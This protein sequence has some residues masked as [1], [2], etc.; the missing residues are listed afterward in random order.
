MVETVAAVAAAP[1][2][3]KKA[4]QTTLTAGG[5][6]PSLTKA[7]RASRL[8]AVVSSLKAGLKGKKF[9]GGGRMNEVSADTSLPYVEFQA[10]FESVGTLVPPEKPTSKVVT[11]TYNAEELGA[12]F[13]DLV[14]KVRIRCAKLCFFLLLLITPLPTPPHS[15]QS[16]NLFLSNGIS[17]TE[18]RKKR[19]IGV[20]MTHSIPSQENLEL[21]PFHC[22]AQEQLIQL[23]L[24]NSSFMCNASMSVKATSL[25]ITATK[26]RERERAEEK[27]KRETT[28]QFPSYCKHFQ[29]LLVI[30]PSAQLTLC[31][32]D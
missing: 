2:K 18:V 21:N 3:N 15:A 19:A 23:H 27:K 26:E 31:S 1:K 9:Y 12:L 24:K 10:I 14:S 32:A 17:K 28:S 25:V 22:K 30:F 7:Q 5:P 16:S 4:V 13:G 20:V 8:K 29:P 6:P 11:R